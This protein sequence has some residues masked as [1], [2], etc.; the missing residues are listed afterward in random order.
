MGIEA[1]I[2]EVDW[3]IAEGLISA[4]AIGGAVAAFQ[5]IEP[6]FTQ[7]LSVGSPAGS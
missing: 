2:A 7:D 5:Y 4:Y 3:M 6:A 1:V